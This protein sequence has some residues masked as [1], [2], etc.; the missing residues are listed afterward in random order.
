MVQASDAERPAVEAIGPELLRRFGDRVR[1]N[2]VKQHIGRLVKPVMEARGFRPYKTRRVAGPS[3]FTKA[4][5]YRCDPEPIAT[6][7]RRHGIAVP[8]D[9]LRD[10]VR[11]AAGDVVGDPPFAKGPGPIDW[12][13]L[14]ATPAPVELRPRLH[15][16]A[17][18]LD[19][20]LAEQH[21]R[22]A[23]AGPFSPLTARERARLGLDDLGSGIPDGGIS[24]RVATALAFGALCATAFTV[25]EAAELLR[26]DSRA[27]AGLVADRRLYGVPSRSARGVRLPLFQFHA[28][29]PVP[30]VQ[31]IL[32]ALDARIH[33]LSVF[34]WFTTPNPDLALEQTGYE[35]T[36]PRDWLLR[37][38]P[39]EPVR[40][41]AAS[42][43]V[44]AAA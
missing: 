25:A 39:S 35:P 29:A 32:P 19:D 43:A 27:V 31:D 17:T 23:D 12:G 18:A 2:K 28:A 11:H 21:R 8:K 26:T 7:L 24:A 33:P 16:F 15:A 20:E 34:D 1:P 4:K 36:S 9:S 22:R 38:H 30:K 10:L 41:L 5:V 42:L 44:G 37:R 3:M 40:Q 14:A 6:V 13:R